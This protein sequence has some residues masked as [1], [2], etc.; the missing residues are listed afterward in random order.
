VFDCVDE[1]FNDVADVKHVLYDIVVVFRA[2]I[3]IVVDVFV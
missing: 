2:A 3:A 1:G